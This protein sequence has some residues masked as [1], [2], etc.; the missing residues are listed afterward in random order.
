MSKNLEKKYYQKLLP[1][2]FTNKNFFFDIGRFTKQKNYIYLVKEFA[3]FYQKNPNEKLLIIGNGEL[4]DNIKKEIDKLNLS[5][6][7]KIL[8][9]T[10]NV[11]YYMRKSKGFILSSLWEEIGFVI[12][13]AA[14]S[15]TAVISSDCKNG[16]KEFLTYGKGG[17]LYESNKSD[18]LSVLLN[19]FIKTDSSS[20]IKKRINAKK[21]CKNFS[22]FGHQ[23]I[24]SKILS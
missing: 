11:Y 18:S 12:V 22:M 1:E 16:P 24:L 13:E 9:Q 14:M 10:D 17:F 3:K 4:K 8:S 2:N 15:N 19:S 20:L 21:N 7:I 5:N 23:I 6:S